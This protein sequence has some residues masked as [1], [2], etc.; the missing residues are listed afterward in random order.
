MPRTTRRLYLRLALQ[1]LSRR[2]TRTTLLALA[3]ALGTGAVFGVL[4]LLLG[5]ERSM[6]AGFRRLGADLLVVPEVTLV[7]LT[8]ALLTVEPTTERIDRRLA[9]ELSRVAGVGRVAPQTLLRVPAPGGEHGGTVDVTAFD[10][11]RDFTVLPWLAEPL[12]RNPRVGEVLLGGRRG[13]R[14]G[15]TIS[16]CGV[17]LRAIGRLERTGVGPFDHGLF[18]TD[19]TAATLA[20]ACRDR[21]RDRPGGGGVPAY[22]P[23][24]VSALLILLDDGATPERVRFAVAQRPGVKVVAGDSPATAI[25][26]GSSVLLGSVLLLA[27]V[28]L[29]SSGLLVGLLFSAI[30]AE[31][32]REIGLLLA[33]GCRRRHVVR[34]FLTEAAVAT[35]LGGLLGVALGAGLLLVFRRSVGYYF[36]TIRVGFAWPPLDT[37]AAT[38]AACVLLAAGIGLVGVAVPAWH[39]GRREPYELI[40]GEAR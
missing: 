24:R 10:P 33:L 7:N 40:R 37:T 31:R 29:S 11:D 19:G 2:P 15:E 32:S 3:V 28:F 4:T 25:R 35:G 27:A 17:A 39:A 13:E 6:T 1:D 5:I 14:V 38:A 22:D 9:D 18:V 30:I 12:D 23:G 26:R 34:L 20:G 8:A 36:E 21:D 16:L